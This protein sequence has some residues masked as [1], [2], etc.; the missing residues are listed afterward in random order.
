MNI[1]S[2]DSTIVVGAGIAGLSTALR[3]ADEGNQVTILTKNKLYKTTSYYAQGGIAAVIDSEDSF[4]L[5]HSDTLEA[6]A[7]LCDSETVKKVI[8]EGPECIK[9]LEDNGVKFTKND[10]NRD[11]HLMREGGHSQRRIVHSDDATGIA[12]MS[13]L[14]ERV[15]NNKNI[16]LIEDCF[17]VDL[18][19][20]KQ[21][22]ISGKNRC[23][24]IS[25]FKV[26]ETKIQILWA[27][28]FV[29]A[30]GGASALYS[31]STNK[32]MGDGIAMAWRA[33]C[34]ISNM[35]FIQFH[36]TCLHYQK[37]P[38]ILISEAL[39]G[40]GGKLVLPDGSSFMER[41]D[42]RLELAPRD[43]VSRSIHSEMINNNIDYVYLDISHQPSSEVKKRFPNI[44]KLCIDYGLDITQEPIPV[45][46]AA[47]YTCGGVT[48]DKFGQT[49][50]QCLYAVG[51][52]SFTGLHGANRL[53]SNSLLEALSFSKAVS[54]QI[55][56]K[57]KENYLKSMPKPESN[58]NIQ[59]LAYS[60]LI[61]EKTFQL[62]ELMWNNVGI[63]RSQHSLKKA[64]S[65]I[66]D[67]EKQVSKYFLSGSINIEILEINNM[68]KVSRLII[69]SA[70]KRHESRGGHY[71]TDFPLPS[72]NAQDTSLFPE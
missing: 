42:N 40:E 25:F 2:S 64:S 19:T 27:N 24:G 46:P 14:S 44:F 52:C 30:T 37:A 11:L 13:R 50:L 47:H 67:L 65:L 68:I 32:S 41:Y 17:V 58:I 1:A 61:K 59:N 29:L 9:W 63:I 4:D 66:Y 10:S 56:I 7:G 51:E 15:R 70:S 22:S 55:K 16:T 72:N 12:V 48:A 26:E 53:A 5:H 8:Q 71:N 39:R 35:E 36:P 6:G 38:S 62:R 43:I 33:G 31:H 49:D 69:D 23:V 34:S 20:T 60:S 28:A 54:N 18:I 21:L 45:T 57:S 3:L